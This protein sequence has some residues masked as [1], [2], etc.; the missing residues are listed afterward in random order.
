MFFQ[1]YQ[2]IR[3]WKSPFWVFRGKIESLSAHNL[4]CQKL[5]AVYLTVATFYRPNFLIHVAASIQ[6]GKM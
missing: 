1:K 4:L 6:S 3:G 5:A 2:L